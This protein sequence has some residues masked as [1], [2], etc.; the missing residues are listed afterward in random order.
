MIVVTNPK[1][2]AE[3]K[4]GVLASLC[5]DLIDV[6]KQYIRKEFDTARLDSTAQA[7]IDT[8]HTLGFVELATEMESDLITERICSLIT[9]H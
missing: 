3:L 6:Q 7:C 5:E 4:T 2:F 1:Q 8:A 9:N